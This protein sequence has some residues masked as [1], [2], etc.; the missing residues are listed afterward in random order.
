MN[1]G[2]TFQVRLE[3]RHSPNR[4]LPQ[5]YKFSKAALTE[6]TDIRFE[7]RLHVDILMHERIEHERKTELLVARVV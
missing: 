7:S 1:S 5:M 6:Q 3:R 2:T 4:Q